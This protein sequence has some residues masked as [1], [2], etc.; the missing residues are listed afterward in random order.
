MASKAGGGIK[1]NKL[2]RP[3]VR[4]GRRAEAINERGVAQFGTARGNHATERAKLLK[5]DVEKVRGA[6]R[7]AG[8][9]GS[10]PL[11]NAVAASTVAGPGGSRTVSHCGS[12]GQFGPVAGAPRPQGRSFDD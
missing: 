8:Q 1:S 9:P 3:S 2:V 4:T 10:V 12:Q 7:K 6:E 11:G 5:G